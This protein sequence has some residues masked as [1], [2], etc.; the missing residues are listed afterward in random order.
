[1]PIFKYTAKNKF[2]ETIKGKVEAKEPKLAASI[3]AEQDLF[4]IDL[5][6]FTSD[7]IAQLKDALFGVKQDDVVNFTRQLSTMVSA[8]LPL[9]N[10]LSILVD[11]SKASFARV[12]A[13]I[14]QD[15]E[16]GMPLAKALEKH[17]KIFS[18]LYIQLVLAGETGGVLDTVLLRL[19]EN[20]EKQKDFRS[21]TKGAMIY[22]MIVIIAMIVV[23]AVMMIFVIPKML[24][25]YNDFGATLPLPTK[26]LIALSSFMVNFWW[27]IGG[28]IAL[29]IAGFVRYKKTDKGQLKIDAITLKLPIV[30]VLITKIALTEFTRTMALLLGAG[31]SLLQTLAIVTEGLENRVFRDAMRETGANVEKGQALSTALTEHPVF[32]PILNQMTKVGEETGKLDEVLKK[33]SEYFESE[34]S[35]AVKNLTTA[36]EPMIMIILGLGVA[37]LVIAIIMPIYNLTSQF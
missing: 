33:L 6:S 14:L 35:Q 19:A 28:L 31:V 11:Q 16:G 25:M 22:P 34:S 9:T 27:A 12:V 5:Q 2:G 29:L 18:R 8:G 15:V 30:G 13:I 23:A 37:F 4:L 26:I 7:P 1:M 36:I 32:P 21:K 20:M 10:S 24:A 17:P 3:L